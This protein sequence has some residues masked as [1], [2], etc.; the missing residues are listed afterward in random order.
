MSCHQGI[1]NQCGELFVR[2]VTGDTLPHTHN[3]GHMTLCVVEP[4]RV[5]L[6]DDAGVT[7]L[8][9]QLKAGERVWVPAEQWHTV[10]TTGLALCIW[11]ESAEPMAYDTKE[12][13]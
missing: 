6:H 7:T 13:R 2:E 8:D 1:E 5:I 11:P 12:T 4:V 10:L 9:L 3:R